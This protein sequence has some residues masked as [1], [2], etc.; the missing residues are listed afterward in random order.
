MCC[1]TVPLP[2]SHTFY[3]SCKE[4]YYCIKLF[5]CHI[6]F[7]KARPVRILSYV[8]SSYYLWPGQKWKQCFQNQHLSLTGRGIHTQPPSVQMRKALRARPADSSSQTVSLRFLMIFGKK[9]P[10]KM[11]RGSSSPP[12]ITVPFCKG[13]PHRVSGAQ[14][15]AQ[16]FDTQPV[17]DKPG[18]L[19]E[20][21]CGACFNV[22]RSTLTGRILKESPLIKY[23][24]W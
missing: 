15:G 24:R 8:L 4:I 21:V 11:V 12:S 20:S 7:L 18:E 14:V 2:W 9:F 16:R 13:R 6:G 5:Y 23:G 1:L 22:S 19:V 3:T 17:R 10:K